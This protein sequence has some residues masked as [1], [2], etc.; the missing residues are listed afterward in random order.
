[1]VRGH[2]S[3]IAD[4][5]GCQSPAARVGGCASSA[6]PGLV[7]VLGE[8]D[9]PRYLVQWEDAHESILY[10]TEGTTIQPNEDAAAS[11]D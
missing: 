11:A 8:E 5:L 7:A 1:M 2:R 4:T 10:P 6:T 9:H 3:L